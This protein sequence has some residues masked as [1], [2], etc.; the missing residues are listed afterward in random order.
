MAGLL[1]L[2]V[3]VVLVLAWVMHPGAG[4]LCTLLLVP[5]VH[6]LGQRPAGGAPGERLR[7]LG[8]P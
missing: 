1:A 8:R 5:L 2:T 4:I 3:L 7:R 6:A